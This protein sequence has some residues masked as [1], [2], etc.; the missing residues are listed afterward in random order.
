MSQMQKQYDGKRECESEKKHV[1]EN[2]NQRRNKLKEEK[3][4][5]NTDSNKIK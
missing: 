3:E 1:E 4:M 2:V 5:T